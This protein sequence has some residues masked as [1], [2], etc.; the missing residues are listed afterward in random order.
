MPMHYDLTDL[1]V[2]VSVA[3]VGNLSRGAERCHLAPST[4][5]LRIKGLEDAIGASLLTRK[6]RGVEL[7]PAGQIL[8]EHARRCLAQLEQMHA[9]LLPFSDGMAN[10]ITFFANNNAIS[11]YL[12]Q[13]LGTFFKKHPSVRISLEERSSHEIV[14]AVASGRADIGIV[15][16]E[17]E[18]PRLSFLPYQ[19]D[20]LVLLAP[21]NS[22]WGSRNSIRFS[23]C[24][25]VPFI[26]LQSGTAIHTFLMNHATALGGTLDVRVKV[27]GYPA[28]ARL[29][30]SGAGV[31]IVPRSALLQADFDSLTVLKIDEPWSMRNLQICVL[32]P[33]REKHYFRDLLITHLQS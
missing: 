21:K 20:E 4:V 28:I 26:S 18:H 11:T 24:L 27:S 22:D 19:Q 29:V 2:F 15:A 16:L 8:L 13:D 32:R 14:T 3:E 7:T 30:E 17:E 25:G 23:D 5:S 33:P 6:A 10:H 31:G 1:K 9:D 12:P